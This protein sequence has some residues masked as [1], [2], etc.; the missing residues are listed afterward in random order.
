MIVAVIQVRMGSSRLPRKVMADILGK[1]MLWHIA[2][3]LRF[4]KTL[5][6]V[7][8]ATSVEAK[9]VPIRAFADEH[10][11]PCFAGSEVDLIDRL[12]GA[13][14]RFGAEAIVRITGD[15]PLADPKIVDEV[16]ATYCARRDGLDY[17]SNILPPTYPDG[18]DTEIY[19][20]TTLK[21]LWEEIADPQA[22]EWFPLYLW[23]NKQKFRIA[24]V[25]F[26]VDLSALRWT[27]DYEDDL[28]FVREVFRRL[29]RKGQV[30]NMEEVLQLLDASPELSSINAKHARN[31]GVAIALKG[32]QEKN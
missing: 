1:P 29:Y 7:V 20:T 11:I 5:D 9:D 4:A 13:A 26:S 6:K 22:R 31:E 27:V 21:R 28:T 12:Y 30:F 15:C 24:N 18:L 17:V 3:R 14:R 23:N 8:I 16:V 32:W 25:A 2:H 19:P 10:G